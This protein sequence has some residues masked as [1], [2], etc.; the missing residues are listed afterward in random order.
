[1][2][3]LAEMIAYFCSKYPYSNELS[4]ARLTKLV[5]LSDWYSCLF[6]SEQMSDIDW[7]FN[8]HGPYVTDVVDIARDHQD[9]EVIS[10]RN[11]YG[12]HKVVIG[13]TGDNQ[14]DKL[15]SLDIEIMDAIIDTTKKMYFSD[16]IDFVYSTYP[17]IANE[18]Y[19]KLNLKKLAQEYLNKKGVEEKSSVTKPVACNA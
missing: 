8:H 12:S 11:H 13:Y 2:K 7:T 16:F 10:T 9:F 14:F 6:Q 19:S 5:Y 17:V 18:R 4:K 15:S 1:M 3:K